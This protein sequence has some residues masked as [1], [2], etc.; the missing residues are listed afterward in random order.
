[1]QQNSESVLDFVCAVAGG[2]CV[3]L[4]AGLNKTLEANY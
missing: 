3:M 4:L 1:M 2:K